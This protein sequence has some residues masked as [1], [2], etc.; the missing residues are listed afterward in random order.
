MLSG[1]KQSGDLQTFVIAAH[2]LAETFTKAGKLDSA[3]YME[4]FVLPMC[5]FS[6]RMDFT[7]HA[8]KR[9][10]YI[11]QKQATLDSAL[12]YSRL[13]MQ[14]YKNVHDTSGMQEMALLLSDLFKTERQVDSAYAY[15]SLY[16]TL[17]DRAS[18][19]EEIKKVSTLLFNKTMEQ[20]QLEQ[21]QKQ[22]H[23]QYIAKVKLY[24]VLAG[25][26]VLLLVV[27][28]LY[29][30][31]LQK[32]K[33]NKKIAK[34]YEELKFTQAQLIQQEKMASLGE[35]TAGIAHEIQNPLNFVNNFFRS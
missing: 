24:A 10:A 5:P 12:Y 18:G 15:L 21:E 14:G 23:L 9:L 16:T 13:A 32:Q 17:K 7:K 27:A 1:A 19:E 31:N 8:Q 29:R 4:D 34:A 2:G 3:L 6:G 20:K 30:N 11:F 22:A 33:A 35:L 26:G 25:L 28:M